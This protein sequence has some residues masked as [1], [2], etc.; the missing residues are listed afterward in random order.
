MKKLIV[1]LVVFGMVGILVMASDFVPY[2]HGS[3]TNGLAFS[4]TNNQSTFNETLASITVTTPDGDK[5]T[6][7]TN[8]IC[9]IARYAQTQ[10]LFSISCDQTA[11]YDANDSTKI[12]MGTIYYF[13]TP[14]SGAV[15]FAVDR[16]E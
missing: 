5:F 4:W 12:P 16:K 14:W 8:V 1:A 11:F 13:T 6:S 7:T 2:G 9:N 15:H 10:T 3:R